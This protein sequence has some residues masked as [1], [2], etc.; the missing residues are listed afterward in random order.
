MEAKITIRKGCPPDLAKRIAGSTPAIEPQCWMTRQDA[1]DALDV[2]P[3]TV[4]R[5]IRRG[6][7]SAYSG[8]VADRSATQSGHGVRVWLADVIDYR[9]NVAV[10]VE[11]R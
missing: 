10:E 2:N 9:T 3:R 8:P 11:Q 4:D 5:Y 6:E 7:L 1:A